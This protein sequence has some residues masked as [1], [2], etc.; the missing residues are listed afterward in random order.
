MTT[1]LPQLQE[2]STLSIVTREQFQQQFNTFTTGIFESFD[3]L[4]IVVISGSVVGALF[5]ISTHLLQE[6]NKD[7]HE[8]KKA[9]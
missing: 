5:S 2:V 1:L 8:E 9:E 4:N 6:T 3:F 7:K